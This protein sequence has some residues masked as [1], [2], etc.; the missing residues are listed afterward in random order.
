MKARLIVIGIIAVF[1]AYSAFFYLNHAQTVRYWLQDFNERAVDYTFLIGS[2]SI[3][4]MPRDLLNDCGANKIYGFSNGTVEDIQ[5][6]LRFAELKNAKK[7]VIYIGENDIARGEASSLTFQQFVNLLNSIREKSDVPIGIASLK[8]SPAREDAHAEFE[9]FNKR[10][11]EL[12]SATN[13]LHLIPYH[14]IKQKWLYSKD[15]IHT[16]NEGT[17][18]FANMINEFCRSH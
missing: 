11:H 15:E 3:A 16:N 13:N 2:S 1:F 14:Q 7:I 18:L 4:R 5:T 6:Y 12:V 8:F 10:L 17:T 9:T